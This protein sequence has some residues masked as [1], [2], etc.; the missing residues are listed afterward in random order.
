MLRHA[1]PS[2]KGSRC[3]VGPADGRFLQ[4]PGAPRAQRP[5]VTHLCVRADSSNRH[6]ELLTREAIDLLEY[7]VLRREG[8]TSTPRFIQAPRQ[9]SDAVRVA[10][11][12]VN[13]PPWYARSLC[14]RSSVWVQ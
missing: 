5:T 12:G 2:G 9:N 7:Q 13:T 11:A 6:A 8:L 10:E 4:I 3:I 14:A 1:I